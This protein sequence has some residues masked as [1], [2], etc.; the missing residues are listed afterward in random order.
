MSEECQAL[1]C[2]CFQGVF[3]DIVFGV[4]EVRDYLADENNVP[5]VI[6]NPEQSGFQT[7]DG[8]YLELN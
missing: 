7:I 8:E 6:E 3:S 4:V 5:F 2:G 1:E